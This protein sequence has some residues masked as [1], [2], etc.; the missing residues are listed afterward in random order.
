MNFYQSLLAIMTQ[1][2][3]MFLIGGIVA[4]GLTYVFTFA[5]LALCRKMNWFEP[6]VAHKVHTQALPRLGGLAIYAAFLV[7]S[8]LFYIPTLSQ[9]PG[10]HEIIF[11][12][13]FP[14]ELIIYGLFV[15]SSL[16]IVSVHAYDDVKG[17]K[18]WPK[19]CAQTIA[20]LL[21]IGPGLHS[22]HGVL[23]FGV[24]NPFVHATTLYNAALP[25]YQQ[26]ELTLFIRQPVVSWLALPAVLFTWFWF[27]GMMNA[28]NFM[29]GLDGLVAGI[30]AIASLFIAIISW[31]MGQYTIATLA[32]IF[33]GAVAG[34]LP[35]NWHPSRI[36]MGDSGSQFL[37]LGLGMLSIMGGA[38]FALIA[39][40]LGIPIL[41][42]AWVMI[43][44]MRRGQSPM[45]RDLLPQYSH[46]THLHYRLLFGGFTPRQVCYLFYTVTAL[47]GLC[48]LNLPRIF[49]FAGF[50]VVGLVVCALF[51]WS[52]YLQRTSTG[53]KQQA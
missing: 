10:Q 47:F 37:G 48:A 52:I 40:I 13:S 25:W 5:V 16:L 31:Q 42:I 20:V 2:P 53:K 17:L 38:K 4:F 30:V 36:I 11:G 26:P 49:K 12:R 32:A 3:L 28:I 14:K 15:L 18:P 24:N 1:T 8:L 34:F 51:W 29:D 39:M 45:Q 35:H 19:L 33:T 7:A 22:F 43:N 41:D 23:F 46:K 6:V 9:Q 21:L 50:G 27:A 44:R